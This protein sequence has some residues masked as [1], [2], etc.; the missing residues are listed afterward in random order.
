MSRR[1]WSLFA[2]MCVIWGIPYLLI[3]VAVAEVAPAL[4]VF[5]RTAGGALLLLP[6]VLH[7]RQLGVVRGRLPAV[8]AFATVELI[9]PWLLLSDAEQ[10][11]S[12]SLTGLLIATVPIIGVVAARVTGDR[13]PITVLRWVG[14]LVGF[15][16]VALLGAPALESGGGWP[17]TEV[18]LT[19]VGYA[20]GPIIADRAL[21]D[22][23]PLT[24][25]AVCLGFT[26][27]VYL[28]TVPFNL[29]ARM[30]S[31]GALAALVGLATVCTALAFV[32]F[33][34]LIAE[35]GP[36]R[37]SVITYVNPAVAAAL[38][39]VVLRERLNV[40]IVAA[41][42]FILVGS[43]LSTRHP[44]DQPGPELPAG[45]HGPVRSVP[46]RPGAARR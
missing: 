17:V 45:G 43:V 42:G 14:L 44:R 39:A 18:L 36:A 31:P 37:A 40:M 9:G 34:K 35:I 32:L 19:A 3:K 30:P 10:H 46:A 11:L 23:P 8:V 28:P 7:R 5:V 26:S 6:L 20:T 41:F 33:F 29:P 1:S 2:A 15:G 4:L 21:R 13:R 16:G 12:S 22:V 38:G 27:L 24:L 25:T